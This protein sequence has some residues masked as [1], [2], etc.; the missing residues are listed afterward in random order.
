MS[1][2]DFRGFLP[3]ELEAQALFIDQS[4]PKFHHSLRSCLKWRLKAGI[5]ST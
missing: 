5:N 4:M 3:S 2:S 1:S